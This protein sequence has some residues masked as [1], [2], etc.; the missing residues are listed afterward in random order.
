MHC[1]GAAVQPNVQ[2]NH[3]EAPW[4]TVQHIWVARLATPRAQTRLHAVARRLHTGCTRGG[5][6]SARAEKNCHRREVSMSKGRKYLTEREVEQLMTQTC[7]S[8]GH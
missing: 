6:V 2:P 1:A 4:P 3:G 7:Y 8:T 5:S